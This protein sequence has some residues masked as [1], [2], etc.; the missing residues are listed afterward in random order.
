MLLTLFGA[1]ES[2]P[3]TYYRKPEEPTAVVSGRPHVRRLIGRPSQI[4]AYSLI[5]VVTRTV[6]DRFCAAF[7]LKRTNSAPLVISRFTVIRL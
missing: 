2:L 1:V 7:N 3:V 4:K 6:S 5:S